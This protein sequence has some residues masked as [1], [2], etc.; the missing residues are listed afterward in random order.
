MGK[1]VFS[2]KGPPHDETPK[3]PTMDVALLWLAY[4][5]VLHGG[6]AH[7]HCI[8]RG[9]GWHV[10]H[11]PCLTQQPLGPFLFHKCACSRLPKFCVTHPCQ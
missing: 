3:D 2:A 1:Q 11:G 10:C 9:Q 4:K 5:S 8:S 7:E 6:V